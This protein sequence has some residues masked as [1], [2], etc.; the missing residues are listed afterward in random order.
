V[1]LRRLKKV[2]LLIVLGLVYYGTFSEKLAKETEIKKLRR[3]IISCFERGR[4]QVA[5]KLF[6]EGTKRGILNKEF[7][8]ELISNFYQNRCK[9]VLQL[10]ESFWWIMEYT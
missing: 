8:S 9:D 6:Q 4:T 5:K 7:S 2:K 1:R 10:G 3:N